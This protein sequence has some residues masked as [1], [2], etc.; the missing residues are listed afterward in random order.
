MGVFL[1]SRLC[2]STP[3]SCCCCHCHI[4][5]RCL[6]KHRCSSLERFF[7]CAPHRPSP[8]PPQQ[9]PAPRPP[10]PAATRSPPPPTSPSPIVS[11][12]GNLPVPLASFNGSTY[13]ADVQQEALRYNPAV[14][15]TV[16]IASVTKSSRRRRLSASASG[17]TVVAT[18]V[19]FA[20]ADVAAAQR[21]YASLQNPNSN[22]LQP[23]YGPRAAIVDPAIW[24]PQSPPPPRARSPPPPPRQ[25]ARPPPPRAVRPPP[26]KAARPPPPRAARPPPPSPVAPVSRK[27]PPPPPRAR[28]PPPPSV[29]PGI[30]TLSIARGNCT[31]GLQ[32]IDPPLSELAF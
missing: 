24:P 2:C 27:P 32:I 13:A 21:F 20:A 4:Q 19:R 23:V 18:R 31:G 14:P 12:D 25:T 5:C 11:Y 30:Y 26:P 15:P 8:P 3:S 17:S 22:F 28:P 7:F 10:P 16:V 1:C 6:C 9:S 29:L